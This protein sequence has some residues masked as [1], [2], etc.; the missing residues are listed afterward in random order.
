MP[1]A[2]SSTPADVPIPAR[3][4]RISAWFDH[5]LSAIGLHGRFRRDCALAVLLALAMAA[6]PAVVLADPAVAGLL[7]T[8]STAVRLSF[9]LL[10]GQTLLLCLRRVAPQLCLGLVVLLQ[11]VMSALL[12]LEVT[13]NGPATAVAVYTCATLLPVRRTVRL[14][15]GAALVGSGGILVALVRNP[16]PVLGITQLLT[17]VVALAAAAL[18]GVSVATRRRYVELVRVHAAE[19]LAAQRRRAE[20]AVGRERNR[21]ARELHDI[22]A[23]HLS[24]MVVQAGVVEQLVDRDPE[25]ARRIA[26]EVRRQGRRTLRDL[27]MVVGTLREPGTGGRPEDDDPVPGLAELDRL[28]E[29]ARELGTPVDLE[30]RGRA[31]TPPPITDVTCYRV[32]QEALANAREHAPGAP[33]RIT[34]TGAPGQVMIEIGSAPAGNPAERPGADRMRGYGLIG[35]RERAQLVGAEFEAGPTAD[36]GWLVRLVVPVEPS[37]PWDTE[38]TGDAA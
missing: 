7:P 26:G 2:L 25:R 13:L 37:D 19:A 22:A 15:A 17:E 23:H 5:R 31:V 18:V 30:H 11:G 3:P 14:V 27:R 33:V 29:T 34:V 38:D 20:A 24:G 12:P 4:D 35:M 36:G 8:E 6:L 9:V 10:T 32:V 1:A 16:A 21:M 28:V